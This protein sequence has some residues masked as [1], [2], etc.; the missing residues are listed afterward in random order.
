MSNT[1]EIIVSVVGVGV[2]VL[3]ALVGVAWRLADRLG[4]MVGRLDSRI[5]Q[6][7]ASLDERLIRVEGRIGDMGAGIRSLNQ[8]VASV[9]GL[10]PTVFMF[11]HRSKAINDEEYD[12]E[13]HE[14]IGGF[15]SRI[16]QGT[17]VLVDY[18]A[19]GI[20]PLAVHEA[21]RFKELVNKARRGEFFTRQ[22]V[23]E[24]DRLISKVQAE[25]PDDSSIW[26]LVPLG[27]FPL[28]LYL[29]RRKEDE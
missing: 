26:P 18:L 27:A 3:V 20:N 7:Q 29:G 2:V 10:L 24:Y 21:Q 5:D 6:A 9:V 4:K 28:G 11:L 8:Q 23:D 16:T 17:E 12:E 15:T 22:E 13:Y 14:T 19:R 25:R 1:L